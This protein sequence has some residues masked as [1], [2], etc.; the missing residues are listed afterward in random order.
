MQGVPSAPPPDESTLHAAALAYLA[1]YAATE[2]GLRRILDRRIDRW[3]RDRDRDEVAGQV[4]E[5]RRAALTVVA[6][7]AESGAVDTAAFAEGRARSLARG[8]R[9][10]RAIAAHLAAK[11][12]DAELVRETLAR[13]P[14][15]ELAAALALA[16]RR[17]IG[18]FR[19]GEP[20]DDAGRR[21]E[22]AVLARAGFPHGIAVQ[23][24]RIGRE[25]AEAMVRSLR[26]G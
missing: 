25:E 6:R 1:R 16:S 9:S 5:A 19:S 8:G 24:L 15:S 4:A 2:A 13:G 17:R 26:Q 21:R 14:S 12:V 11:G 18:P 23:A 7:L 10:Q 22:L 3:A 20:P